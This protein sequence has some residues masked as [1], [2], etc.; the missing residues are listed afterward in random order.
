MSVH[1]GQLLSQ[2]AVLSPSREALVTPTGRWTYKQL[3]QR[4]G[5]LASYLDS[6]G[7]TQG[8][9]I[10][11]LA[12]NSEMLGSTLFAAGRLGATLVVLNWRLKVEE[13]EYILSDCTPT[14]LVY[15]DDFAQTVGQL[16]VSR[17]RLLLIGSGPHDSVAPYESIV[18]MPRDVSPL[19]GSHGGE[20]PAVIMYTSGTTGHPKGAMIS[21]KA[22]MASS[23]ANVCTLDWRQDHRFLL[24]AP[25]F[26]IGGLSPLVTN[27]LKGCT[28]ILQPDFE[29][30][31]VWRTI[32]QERVT[33]LM[34][35]PV[36]LQ[37]LLGVAQKT[38]V[39]SS[40][41]QWVTCGA[42]AVPRPLI[43]AGMAA[44]IAVQQVYGST[45]FGG[46][47]SFWTAE[48][49]LDKAGSQGKA[50]L[51]GEVKVVDI[52]TFDA[53][54]PGQKG[55][56]CCRGPMMFD[57]YWGNPGATRSALR[58]GWYRTGDVGYLDDDGFIHVVDRCKDMI[59][60]GGENI[61]PAELE[62]VILGLP[63][64]AEVAVVG[65]PDER[66]GEV[67]VAF[68]VAEAG[69]GLTADAVMQVCREKLAGFKCV[70]EVRFI[71]ALPRSA[72]GKVLK[73]ALL[74]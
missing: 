45:E 56:I 37:A 23:Q 65:R 58:D 9:R 72:V 16:A 40:S 60:S 70:K 3:D 57:G 31:Q 61:Y 71:E 59:I 32:A 44:G 27:V 15:E 28:T 18:G 54:A 63:G 53:L 14:V 42:S 74:A 13:L 12:R 22:M 69:A 62:A 50:L 43:E 1:L 73:R 38:Q 35:V 7:V 26:H 34:T 19:L 51:G 67:P 47:I 25:M 2:R 68:V 10:A 41:L 36:M 21:H 4:V 29:P 20:H 8:D 30:L 46:A 17:P 11:V 24:I 5:R 6:R 48:M 66:W 33:S 52:E 39:D 64:I 49:G 55:E